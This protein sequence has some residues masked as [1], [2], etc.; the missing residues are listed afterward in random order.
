MERKTYRGMEVSAEGNRGSQDSTQ[1]EDTPEDS[2]KLALLGLS[3]VG[4]HDRSLCGPKGTGTDTENSTSSDDEGTS[5]GVDVHCPVICTV[6]THPRDSNKG[7]GDRGKY[8]SQV[9]TDVEGVSHATQEEGE[10]RT[11]LVVDRTVR[12]YG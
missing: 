9:R 10:T 12:A 4:Q 7:F 5:T 8:D 2:D 6:S 11:K 3:G 1:V